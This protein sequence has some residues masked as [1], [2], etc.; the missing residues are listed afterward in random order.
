MNSMV[1]FLL[2]PTLYKYDIIEMG[3]GKLIIISLLFSAYFFLV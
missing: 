3:A 2:T 1:N